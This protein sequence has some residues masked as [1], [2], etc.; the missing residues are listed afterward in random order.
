[1]NK[2]TKKPEIVHIEEP[3]ASGWKFDASKVLTRAQEKALGIPSPE[4][5]ARMSTQIIHGGARKGAGRKKTGH[6]RLQI[7][8]SPQ[9]RARIVRTARREGKTLSAVIESRF[10]A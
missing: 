1:M 4:Q 7:L 8:L 3:R 6:V 5:A 9:A 2:K 10:A